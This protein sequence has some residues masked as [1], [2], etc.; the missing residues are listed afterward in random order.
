ILSKVYGS[1]NPVNV[2]KAAFQALS[3][4]SSLGDMARRRDM[5]PQELS[6]RRSRREVAPAAAGEGAPAAAGEEAPA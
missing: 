2:V 4:L 1:N 6:A 5:T 3:E